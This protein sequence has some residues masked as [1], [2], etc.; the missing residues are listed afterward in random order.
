[1]YFFFENIDEFRRGKQVDSGS[2]TTESGI[3]R[4]IGVVAEFE[5]SLSEFVHHRELPVNLVS[6]HPLDNAPSW[7]SPPVGGIL[8]YQTIEPRLG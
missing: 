5:R 2:R 8:A 4:L 7:R 3:A 6:I 1:M